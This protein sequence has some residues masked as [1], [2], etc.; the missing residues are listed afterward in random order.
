MSLIY[1]VRMTVGTMVD[2]VVAGAFF[3]AE[4]FAE[5]EAVRCD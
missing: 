5:R 3:F 1:A 2:V 4:S